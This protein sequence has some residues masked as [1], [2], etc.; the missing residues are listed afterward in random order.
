VTETIKWG[1]PF[2]EHGS[3]LCFM[4]AFQQ[5]CAFGFWK[6]RR[7][8]ADGEA[9]GGAMGQLGRLR[10]VSELPS[11]R[12]LQARIRRALRQSAAS[13]AAVRPA[14]PARRPAPRLPAD[15]GRAL[16]ARP[17]ARATYRA[18]PP[19]GR[20]EYV[21]WLAGAKRAETRA[22]RLVQA[23][24]WLAAGKPFNWRYA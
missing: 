11:R 13:A 1:M 7:V 24:G 9:V 4:A 3:P 15:L 21:E 10:A 6:S 2:F 18:L 19:S 16:A 22:R 12:A 17:A 14:R 5:H 8:L 20:R 23:V